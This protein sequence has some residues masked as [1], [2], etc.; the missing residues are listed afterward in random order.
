MCAQRAQTDPLLSY[1][2]SLD[3]TQ[4]PIQIAPLYFS[5]MSG[6]GVEYGV[7]EHKLFTESG[8]PL[9]Q[10]VP[11]LP[12]YTPVTVKRGITSDLSLWRWHRMVYE[13]LLK[14]ARATI[15]ITLH[16]MAYHPIFM[17]SLVRAWPSKISGFQ[18]ATGSNDVIMQE[19]T[20]VYE[21]IEEQPVSG[22]G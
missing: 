15:S 2:F 3:I 18:F 19:L 9:L 5:E 10:K 13:G 16:D 14:D 6:L 12:T 17:W 22:G 20:L 8:L 11:G 1:Q 7:I 4:G 21:E